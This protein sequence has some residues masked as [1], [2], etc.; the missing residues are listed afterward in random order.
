M[1][2]TAEKKLGIFK[3]FLMIA[4]LIYKTYARYEGIDVASKKIKQLNK[5]INPNPKRAKDVL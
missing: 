2:L 1:R 3:L 4:D 5:K